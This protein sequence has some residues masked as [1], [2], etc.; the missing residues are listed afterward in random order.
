[1]HSKGN[2]N[3]FEGNTLAI[4]NEEPF[5]N[6]PAQN[7]WWGDPSGP[8]YLSNPGGQGDV[9]GGTYAVQVDA[10]PFLTE[11][12]DLQN[13]PPVVRVIQWR[14]SD[15]VLDA[16]GKVILN[17]DASDDAG[18]VT[19]R[20]LWNEFTNDEPTFQLIAEL[21]SAQRSFEW[22]VPLPQTGPV[23][24]RVEAIDAAGRS[25][26][27]EFTIAVPAQAQ[28]TATVAFTTDLTG[29]FS[30]GDDV[31]VCF[32]FQ[33]SG[34]Y[35]NNAYLLL[36]GDGALIGLGAVGGSFEPCIL[37]HPAMPDYSTDLA[38]F[39]VMAAFGN[40]DWYLSDYFAIRPDPRLG[41]APP[42]VN[43]LKPQG[44]E[45]FAGES[46]VAIT[47][48]A[49]DD[50]GI[51]S[52]DIHA[53]FDGGRRWV[54][55][56]FKLP[57]DAAGYNWN[58]PASAG[59]AD[60]RVR[61]VARDVRFQNSS[62]TSAPFAITSGVPLPPGDLDGDGVVDLEDFALWALCLTGPGANV[63]PAECIPQQFDRADLDGD[64][65]VDLQDYD[66]FMKAMGAGS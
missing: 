47:W 43:L 64:G 24:F 20:I 36:E 26:W 23:Y 65:D 8:N 34:G 51:R 25:G 33:G 9:I 66:Y 13:Q 62:S 7:N 18:I 61:I 15:L 30:I 58:L 10:M 52:F 28:G 42:I 59:I 4:R 53:S 5:D 19:Q 3:W 39:A 57:G 12:P 27:D 46:V 1:V 55:V 41:D 16:G 21:P 22:T 60:V 6:I 11:P 40:G 37:S 2:P 49:A 44:G 32:D 48:T 14:D 35:P 29:P 56:A 31:E 45:Q 54:P 63:P 50:Q 17:W 38:R